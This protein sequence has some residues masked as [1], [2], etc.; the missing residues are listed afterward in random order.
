[1]RARY[2]DSD[3]NVEKSGP[4]SETLEITVMQTS[5]PAKPTGLLPGA[6][7]D[8]VLLSWTNPGD[9]SITGYQVLRG[10]DANSL[11][12]LT[13]DTG[14]KSASY[15]DSTVSA[16]TTYVYAIRARNAGGLSP[17]SDPVSVRTLAAPEEEEEPETDKQIAGADFT[18]DGQALDTTGTCSET[19]VASVLDACT[20]NIIIKAPVFAVV[21]TL[22]SN[23]RISIKTGRNKTAVDGATSS[24][25]QSTLRGTD[26]TATLSFP[27][28]RNLMRLWGDEDEASGDSEEHF[29][30][31][32]V[33]PSWTLDGQTLPTHPDCRQDKDASNPDYS[34]ANCSVQTG[35]TG[36]DFQFVN[37]LHDH[38][39][40]YVYVNGNT[41][42]NQPGSSNIG[43]SVALSL[44]QG[45]NRVKVRLAT[46]NHDH[47]P[48]NYRD[49]AFYYQVNVGHTAE[50]EAVKS[51]V[52]EGE[53]EVQ[54]RVTLS[55]AAPAGG[56]DVMVE[57]TQEATAD[58]GPIADADLRVHTVNIPQGQTNAILEA[59]TSRNEIQ[60]DTNA[61]NAE[62]QPGTGYAVGSNSEASVTVLDR[63]KVNV[64][65]A[66][67][68]GQT[69]TVGEGDGEA[70][71][72]MVFDNPVAFT[73]DVVI[74]VFGGGASDNNDYTRPNSIVFFDHLQT[75]ATVTVPILE[76][77]QLENTE[78]FKVW[79][80]RKGLDSHILTPTCGQSSPHL[81]IEITDNDTANIVLDAPE[82]VTEGQPI[83]LGLG[84]RPNVLCPVQ[85][86]FTT[87]LTITGDTD[88]LQDSPGASVSLELSPCASPQNVHI[89]NDD[90]TN[91]EPVW[92][93]ID[94]PGL[95][96]N[97]QVTFTI[98]PLMSSD[99]LVSKLIPE[100][101]SATVII[102]DKPNS[103]ATGSDIIAGDPMVGD[104]LTV[105]TG[106]ISD[107]DGMT[108]A[109]FTYQ[110][111]KWA[112][113]SRVDLSTESTYTVQQGDK[114]DRISLRVS[115]TDDE[116]FQE[117][118]VA[119]PTAAVLPYLEHYFGI[120]EKSIGEPLSGTR[121][122]GTWVYLSD[123]PMV[124][125][126]DGTS[127]RHWG[128]DP[129]VP[130]NIPHTVTYEDGVEGK[131]H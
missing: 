30:R 128:S 68:C 90:G 7:H 101:R 33:L 22:D 77:T 126:D 55:A 2:H 103:K 48:E 58:P 31:V 62:I 19:D 46:K 57:L 70:S 105:D 37:T 26:Q 74:T 76:D 114:G 94:R 129:V 82:E 97:R 14:S 86:P 17:Q 83:K 11:T 130:F 15:T 87:T 78:S 52:I 39:N 72:D 21:G 89:E 112:D 43:D 113:G 81:T 44:N 67:G 91:S 61:V 28:G 99:S 24:A 54:F 108:N 110:W 95:Q 5:L 125:S 53:E 4:W 122:I 79:I 3:G 123:W 42:I 8:S 27:E 12:V 100:R 18:L 118:V 9:D 41:A 106:A 88:A 10:P 64:R 92:Q 6:S 85:F 38:Y 29:Y 25:D 63:D 71:F 49:E 111:F 32:N 117:E 47:V 115:F 93:T 121:K 69:I 34:S 116:G 13:D 51:P 16:E 109:Q 60:S 98:G 40:V 23:D 131:P 20:V 107:S 35:K 124:R 1:M 45:V 56:V 80:T 73:V 102:R 36:P 75:R 127:I 66:D 104:T 50:I 65:F 119:T 120:T 59:L 96:G 84:P